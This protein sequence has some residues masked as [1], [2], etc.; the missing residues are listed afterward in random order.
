MHPSATPTTSEKDNSKSRIFR[1]MEDRTSLCRFAHLRAR[2]SVATPA[3]HY[4]S[5]CITSNDDLVMALRFL[6]SGTLEAPSLCHAVVEWDI[7][8]RTPGGTT[9]YWLNSERATPT[10]ILPPQGLLPNLHTLRF[11]CWDWPLYIEPDFLSA[12]R[13]MTTITQL[14]LHH[15][16]FMLGECLSTILFNLPKLTELTLDSVRWGDP[17]PGYGP[18]GEF[19]TVP[20]L[21][22]RTLPLRKLRIRSPYNYGPFFAWLVDHKCVKVRHLELTMFD[23]ENGRHAA[24]YVQYLGSALETLVC[25]LCPPVQKQSPEDNWLFLQCN[26]R[27]RKLSFDIYDAQSH[28]ANW[29]HKVLATASSCPLTTVAFALAL[30]SR[31]TLWSQPWETVHGLLTTGWK[32][33]LREVAITHHSHWQFV[34]DAKP[35][36]FARFPELA[37][38]GILSVYNIETE[39]SI[40]TRPRAYQ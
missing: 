17:T 13:H 10:R 18:Q 9:K 30:G 3:N 7:N 38:R 19:T 20:S 35:F 36:F 37:K 22:Q 4:K 23:S 25:G 34:A 11:H 24:W 14:H 27:L 8:G 1:H 29:I 12:L 33:S 40:A 31:Q 15:C 21:A 26:P 28:Y 16:T 39:D 6:R 32:S 5:A 2:T